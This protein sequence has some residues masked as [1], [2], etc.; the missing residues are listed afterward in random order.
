MHAGTVGF[1][2]LCK[3]QTMFLYSRV[4]QQ[5]VKERK[6]KLSFGLT[7]VKTNNY[8]VLTDQINATANVKT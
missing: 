2:S 7:Q 1:D 6:L 4:S 3:G 5:T 8:T